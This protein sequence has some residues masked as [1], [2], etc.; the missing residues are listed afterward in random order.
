M[1]IATV[2]IRLHGKQRAEHFVRLRTDRRIG[3][4]LDHFVDV[5]NDRGRVGAD[6]RLRRSAIASNT[7]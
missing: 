1:Q 4:Q 6:Q 2:E 5:A 3:C 7:G